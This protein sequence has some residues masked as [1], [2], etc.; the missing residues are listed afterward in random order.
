MC[1]VFEQA[2]H[3]NIYG[4]PNVI[5]FILVRRTNV[6]EQEIPAARHEAVRQFLGFDVVQ[7]RIDFHEQPPLPFHIAH[8][9]GG[10]PGS[11]GGARTLRKQEKACRKDN[12]SQTVGL[13]KP[14]VYQILRR[15]A[16]LFD[17]LGSPEAGHGDHRQ[18]QAEAG[19][20]YTKAVV[21]K[22][23]PCVTPFI[24]R[25][26]DGEQFIEKDA[27]EH[28]SQ[29]KD[30]GIDLARRQPYR[31]RAGTPAAHDKPDAEH[32]S[33]DDVGSINGGHEVQLFRSC[34]AKRDAVGK[35]QHCGDQRTEHDLEHRHVPE[36]EYPGK[37]FRTA[38]TGSFESHP[39]EQAD[40]ESRQ[41][42]LRRIQ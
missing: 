13:K 19:L 16:F 26:H 22:N 4:S 35:S 9:L 5:G 6:H 10:C 33:A 40:D 8:T 15:A 41:E 28:R 32:Q 34:P 27:A 17:I 3:G 31:S 20:R 30:E 7:R 12:E 36:I 18:T 38:E 39:E 42:G 25:L 24:E 2:G 11:G 37:P 29:Q 21:N 1:E 23:D 14:P